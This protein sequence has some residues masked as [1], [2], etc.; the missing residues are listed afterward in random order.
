MKK[1]EV[2]WA[3]FPFEER[4]MEKERPVIVVG[5][6]NNKIM[7]IKLTTHNVRRYDPF[8]IPITDWKKAGLNHKPTCRVAH[9]AL[10]DREKFIG[11]IGKLSIKDQERV[12]SLYEKYLREEKEM[13]HRKPL[14]E[15][16]K[17]AKESAPQRENQNKD[18]PEKEKEPEKER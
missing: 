17:E 18:R 11:K 16:L 8:D 5:F 6:E 7:A 1:W 9:R 3:S 12:Y 13:Q 2:W 10:I 14:A 4:Q 15:Q